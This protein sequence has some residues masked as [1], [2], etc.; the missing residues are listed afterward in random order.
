MPPV[1]ITI[2]FTP[3]KDSPRS[4]LR[5]RQIHGALTAGLGRGDD[6]YQIRVLENG[7]ATTLAWPGDLIGLD[8]NEF[9][10]LQDLA[11]IKNIKVQKVNKG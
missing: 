9:K 6:Q 8:E 3:T 10:Q 5:L 2:T 1:L 7:M 4:I 11:G